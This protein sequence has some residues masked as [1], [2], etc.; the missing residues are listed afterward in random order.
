MKRVV[1]R[2]AVLVVAVGLAVG[3]G[4][5]PASADTSWGYVVKP[6]PKTSVGH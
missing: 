3:A 6:D 2:M 4:M 5:A 1:R